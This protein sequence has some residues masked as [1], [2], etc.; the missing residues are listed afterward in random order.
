M[1][2]TAVTPVAVTFPFAREPLS[3]CYVRVDTD[4][5]LVGWGEACDSYGC[6]FANV[7]GTA[8]T[9]ALA[10]LVVG[11]DLDAVEP[12]AD[13]MRAWTRRRL[14]D[15]WVGVQARSAVEIALWDLVGQSQGRPV[16]QLLGQV[17]DRVAVYASSVFLEEGDASWH[18]DLLRPLLERGVGMVKVR[19]GPEWRRD[20]RTL[21]DLRGRLGDGVELMVDGSEIFTLPTALAVADGLADLGVTWFEEPL[22]QAQRAGIEELA[23]RSPVAIAYGEHLYGRD[24][25]LDAL[26]RGQMSVLQPDAATCGGIA[27]ARHIAALATTYGARVVPHVAAGP[28]ALAAGVHLAASVPHIR[29]L[30]YPYPLAEAWTTLGVGADLSPAAIV[31]GALPVPATPGLG[32]ALDE[33]AA[34]ARPYRAPGPRVGLPDRFNGDR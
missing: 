2:I 29:A 12:L 14:G 19:V 8:I 24:D 17:R 26:R 27:E 25:A 20:L 33:A 32:V 15:Q 22:P 13:R 31:D 10:P 9:D 18:H 7:V 1:K 16:A 30:E 28:L 11:E 5:G 4:D 23:R 21:A 34:A 6:T 3:F